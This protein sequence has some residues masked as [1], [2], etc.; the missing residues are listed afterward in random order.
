MVKRAWVSIKLYFVA[1]VLYLTA[2]HTKRQPLE[3]RYDIG[4]M[5]ALWYLRT[6]KAKLKLHHKNH[7]PLKAGVAFIMLNESSIDQEIGLCLF[8]Q[9]TIHYLNKDKKFFKISKIW[10]K[11]LET[12]VYPH[13]IDKKHLEA[14]RDILILCDSYDQIDDGVLTQLSQAHYPLVLLSINNSNRVLDDQPLKRSVVDVSFHIP[15][16]YEEYEGLSIKQIKLML[17]ERKEGNIY[18]YD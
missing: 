16:V 7:V 18:E 3:V 11:R 8:N 1:L 17:L 9:T 14:S 13:Q 12:I 10:Q 4:R 5:W 2:L 15:I 6:L